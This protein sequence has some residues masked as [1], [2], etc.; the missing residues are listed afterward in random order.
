MVKHK[1]NTKPKNVDGNEL[2]KEL[3]M[4]QL[5]N[6]SQYK[7]LQYTDLKRVCKYI[8]TSIFDE[9]NCCMWTGYVTNANNSN[10]GTYINFYFRKKKA[11]LHRLLYSNFVGELTDNEYL[12]FSCENKGTCCNIRHLRKFKYQKKSECDNAKTVLKETKTKNHKI[13]QIMDISS[14][15]TDQL[16]L[17]FD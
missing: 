15:L 8:N 1:H 14:G 7:K 4:K 10:K 13:V 16:T 11:A 6:V 17:S 12:K 2:L 9:N 3:I 5:K